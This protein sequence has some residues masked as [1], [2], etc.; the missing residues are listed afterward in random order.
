[1]TGIQTKHLLTRRLA[2]PLT[3]ARSLCALLWLPRV[4]MTVCADGV[5]DEARRER[6]IGKPAQ[7]AA[8]M[9][10]QEACDIDDSGGSS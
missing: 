2:C 5:M 10:C 4:F 3:G 6:R 1:M 9:E 7:Q 8:Y